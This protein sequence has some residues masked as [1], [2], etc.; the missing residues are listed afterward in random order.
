M[1]P[2]ELLYPHVQPEVGEDGY[3][4]GAKILVDFFKEELKK[5]LTPDLHPLGRKIIEC[6]LDDGN[7]EDYQALVPMK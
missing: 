7:I 5:F 2:H 3:E 4:K 6:C 1:I